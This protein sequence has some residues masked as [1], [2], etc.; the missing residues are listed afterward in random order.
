MISAEDFDNL[1][2]LKRKGGRIKRCRPGE[3][4]SDQ[5]PPPGTPP[6][7]VASDPDPSRI[8][9]VPET[10]FKRAS[11]INAYTIQLNDLAQ[12]MLKTQTELIQYQNQISAGSHS[13]LGQYINEGNQLIQQLTYHT[14]RTRHKQVMHQHLSLDD[15]RMLYDHAV[16]YRTQSGQSHP[17]SHPRNS[18][19]VNN[20]THLIEALTNANEYALEPMGVLQY[21]HG[22]QQPTP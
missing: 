15:L 6:V 19:V 11:R 9:A 3:P 13:G 21:Y 14:D 4:C 18:A 5:Q 10:L 8:G 1:V 22:L 20:K 16:H 7:P 2:K 17:P 12:E